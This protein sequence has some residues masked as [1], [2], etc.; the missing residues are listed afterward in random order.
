[1]GSLMY[2]RSS[3]SSKD[4]YTSQEKDYETKNLTSRKWGRKL[5]GHKSGKSLS[6]VN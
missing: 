6:Q 5:R 4:V 2:S 3:R 1:M